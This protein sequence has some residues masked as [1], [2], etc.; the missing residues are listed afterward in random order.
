MRTGAKRGFS[1]E[2]Q[3]LETVSF[4]DA[5]AQVEAMMDTGDEFAE[6][7]AA[8]AGDRL[9]EDERAALWLVAWSLND[10]A[11]ARPVPT[12]GRFSYR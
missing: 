12:L 3:M 9:P 5:R 2:M 4:D 7:E 11:R 10:R 1:G 6:V 8:I